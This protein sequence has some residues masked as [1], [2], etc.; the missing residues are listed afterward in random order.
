MAGHGIG[1]P[2]ASENPQLVWV[3][4]SFSPSQTTSFN[5]QGSGYVTSKAGQP[6]RLDALAKRI[7]IDKIEIANRLSRGAYP[8]VAYNLWLR[9]SP[10]SS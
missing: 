7:A 10:S 3:L 4:Q 1:V 5:P 6:T 2:R 9:Q 8:R